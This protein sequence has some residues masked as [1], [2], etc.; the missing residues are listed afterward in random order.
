[1][2]AIVFS[3]LIFG[4]NIPYW[5][6]A[7]TM[8]S[9]GLAANEMVREVGR[10]WAEI[11]GLRDTASMSFEERA[12]KRAAGQ[13][14]AKPDYARCI[15][16][17]TNASLREMIAPAALVILS[18][19]LTGSFWGVEAVVGLLAGALSSSVQLAI[20]MSNTGGAWD[21]SKKFCEKGGLNGWFMFRTGDGTDM[22]EEDFKKAAAQYNG[23]SCLVVPGSKP[24][25]A[26]K[27][28]GQSQAGGPMMMVPG[29][30]PASMPPHSA[31]T[32]PMMAPGQAFGYPSYS[33]QV[34]P[35][36]TLDPESPKP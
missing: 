16:I 36:P 31:S 11:P 26:S 34:P 2:S 3:F 33:V 30:T 14:L 8:K 23:D 6:S 29:W 25:T 19:I 10:Q 17:S 7:L 32:M 21:N 9:V 35:P 20:S 15:E 27:P 28:Q 5:F 22:S 13:T 12:A 24:A 18:P 1:M 4:A